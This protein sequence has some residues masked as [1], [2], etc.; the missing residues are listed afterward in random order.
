LLVIKADSV[1]AV[2]NKSVELREGFNIANT[3]MSQLGLVSEIQRPKVRHT[4]AELSFS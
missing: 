2:V 4:K 3:V 1:R